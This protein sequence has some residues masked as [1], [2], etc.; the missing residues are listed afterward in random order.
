LR[1]VLKG[2]AAFPPLKKPDPGTF[3][4]PGRGNN[5][6][7]GSNPARHGLFKEEAGTVF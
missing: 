6:S 5:T 7:V 3:P 4:E 2:R 1:T